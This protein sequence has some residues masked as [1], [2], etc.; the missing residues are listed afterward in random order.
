MQNRTIVTD[1]AIY[2]LAAFAPVGAMLA[3]GVWFLGGTASSA[4]KAQDPA[5]TYLDLRVESAREIKRALAKP[6]PRPEPLGPIQ[7]R[8]A[9]ASGGAK[10]LAS[11][12]WRH[13][14]PAEARDAFA[15]GNDAGSSWSSSGRTPS[16]DRHTSNF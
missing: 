5:K 2:L 15:S 16:Y 9:N 3:A 10:A 13:R 12:S 7:T 6:I 4:A 14:L 11:G 1:T 8:A